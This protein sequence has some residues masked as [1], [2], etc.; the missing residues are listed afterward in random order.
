[1]CAPI[2]KLSFRVSSLYTSAFFGLY[3]IRNAAVYLQTNRK[4]QT[5]HAAKASQIR[6]CAKEPQTTLEKDIKSLAHRYF[7]RV[8]LKTGVH[9]SS[10]LELWALKT[11]SYSRCQYESQGES[12]IANIAKCKDQGMVIAIIKTL[13]THSEMRIRRP[14]LTSGR[15]IVEFVLFTISKLGARFSVP[16]LQTWQL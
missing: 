15:S 14:F 2:K 7:F 10:H 13:Q 12:C 11:G 8:D 4:T 9:P 1:M 5:I 16:N 6:Q 3:L